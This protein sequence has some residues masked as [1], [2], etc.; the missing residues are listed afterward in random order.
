[1]GDSYE[2]SL[3]KI[4]SNSLYSCHFLVTWC[5][6]DPVMARASTGGGGKMILIIV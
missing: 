3:G 6:C 1:M 2:C 4:G 5:I